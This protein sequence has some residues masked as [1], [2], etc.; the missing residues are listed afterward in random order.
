MTRRA[1]VERQR[2]T[3][4]TTIEVSLVLDGSG[5]V[6]VSTGLPFFGVLIG[7][8]VLLSLDSSYAQS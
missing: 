5:Q 3:K 6:S 8:A 2:R 1:L 4:E 7:S